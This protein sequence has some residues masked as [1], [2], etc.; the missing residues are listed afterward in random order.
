MKMLEILS[1]LF[2]SGVGVIH[3]LLKTYADLRMW[4]EE[5]IKVDHQW[6]AVAIEKG[7]LRGPISDYSWS[8]EDKIPTRELRGTH[9]VVVALNAEKK[10]KYRIRQGE[11]VLLTKKL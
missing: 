2:I 1:G 10:I 9:Q 11:S 3:D 4:K 7:V 6:L 8:S 5:D